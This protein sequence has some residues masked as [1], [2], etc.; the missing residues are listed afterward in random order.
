MKPR[1]V[2]LLLAFVLLAGCST[3]EAVQQFT[4]EERFALG[5][6]KFREEEYL[7]A[8]EDFKVVTLQFQGSKVA[9]DA[10]YYMAE[11]RFQREE[12][13]LASYEYDVLIR[14]MPT[15]EYISRARYRKAL[16]YYDLSPNSYLDQDYSK[17]AIDEF[18]SFLEYHPTDSLASQAEAHITELNTKLAKKDYDNG[19]TYMKMDYYRAAAY[20]FD[21]VIEKYHDTPYA[22]P[23][24]LKKA[25][26]LF[27]RKKYRDA[28][29]ELDRF[30]TRYP[31]STLK[32]DAEKLRSDVQD[33]LLHPEPPKPP[34]SIPQGARAAQEPKS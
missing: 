22:E 17:K 30:F 9:D 1:F 19:V 31:E 8:I 24:H 7:E 32:S 6:A 28:N 3:E 12:Y 29:Q 16:C 13:V 23:A 25:E 14:T 5:M 18:Q 27:Q 33:R 4:A 21:L 11:C 2:P 10:Q 15:S 20:Y 34:S 26:A